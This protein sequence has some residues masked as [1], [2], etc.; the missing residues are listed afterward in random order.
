MSKGR[1][2]LGLVVEAIRSLFEKPVTRDYPASEEVVETIRGMPVLHSEKCVGC[3]L[4]ERSCPSGAITMVVVGKRKIGNKEVPLRNPRFDYFR[5]IYC[6][7]CSEVCPR[8]AIEMVKK[9][10]L[11]YTS[12]GGEK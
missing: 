8:G 4:C 9:F 10:G 1:G 7:I 5:C 3:G 11:I 6:G 12:K 2:G